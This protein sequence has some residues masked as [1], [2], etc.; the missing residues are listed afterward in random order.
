MLEKL[1]R[2][3]LA[4][5]AIESLNSYIQAHKLQPG[6]SLPSETELAEEFGVSR[7][8]IR[9][10]LKALQGRGILEISNGRR[11]TIK[12]VDSQIL[13]DF[14]AR[15]ASLDRDTIVEVLELRRGLEIECANL[16]A[17][18]RGEQDCDQMLAL[19]DQMGQA[20]GDIER[21][22]RYDSQL[23]LLIARATQNKMLY[24]LVHSLHQ[25]SENTMR[26]GLRQR[27]SHQQLQDV[28]AMHQQLVQAI[29]QRDSAKAM[30]SMLAHLNAAIDA[31]QPDRQSKKEVQDTLTEGSW[32]TFSDYFHL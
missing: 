31:F 25:V 8:V 6:A 4:E 16:A 13:A 32:D 24:H 5:Q 27:E 26:A 18:R 14:F 22:S 2:T 7:Q 23:H 1:R 3:T 15:A 28:H 12:P 9:E 30:A 10:A 19:L 21:Y 11:A 20:I 17:Q 29:I